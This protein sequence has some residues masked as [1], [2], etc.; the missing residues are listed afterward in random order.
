MAKKTA[1]IDLG[2]NS[3]R[4]VIFEKTSRY[5]FYIINECKHKVRL[6]E[7]A[8]NNGQVLQNKAILRAK[9]ALNHFKALIKKEK[10]SKTLI[11]GTSALRDAPNAKDFIKDIKNSLNLNIKC[12]DG[13]TESYLGGIAALNLLDNIKDATTLDIG[14]GSSELCLIKDGK[15]IDNISLDIGTVRLKELFYG[16]NKKKALNIFLN[17]ILNL[18]PS[19]FQNDKLIAIGGSLRAISNSIMN[20]NSYPLKTLHGFCYKLKD[21]ESFIDKILNAN[22]E[23]LMNYGIKKDRLDTIKEGALIF[24]NIAHKLKTKEII[25]SGVGVREGVYLLDIL[26]KNKSFPHNFNPSI[27]ALQD[28]FAPK[29]KNKIQYYINELF[30]LLKDFHNLDIKFKQSLLNAAKI[31]NIGK[32]LNF[33][34]SNE[35]SFYFILNTLIYKLSHKEKCLIAHLIKADGKKIDNKNFVKL[36]PSESNFIWL[37]FI[38]ALSKILDKNYFSNYKLNFA[39]Y[40]NTLYIYAN[41]NINISQY[42]MKKLVIPKA[43]NI[44]FNENPINLKF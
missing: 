24:I 30:E 22:D 20:K 40:K 27:R 9:L 2:S 25:T 36:L 6:G 35:H 28:R 19:H 15:I 37:N 42:T 18:I 3:I 14:G 34:Y 29:E 1:I 10:C 38:L 8:Y 26:P 23:N 13:R 4:L 21:E 39:L 32:F 43:I 44:I 31:C 12:I 41:D 17:E 16:K 33:Y 5:A 7:N 11:I